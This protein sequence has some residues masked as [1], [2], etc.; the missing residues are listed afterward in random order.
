ME[1]HNLLVENIVNCMKNNTKL[2]INLPS[3]ESIEFDRAFQPEQLQIIDNALYPKYVV[4][5]FENYGLRLNFFETYSVWV[6]NDYD[7]YC[8]KIKNNFENKSVD[9]NKTL[10]EKIMKKIKSKIVKQTF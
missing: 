5:L 8:F 1:N 2:L 4:E 6:R 10:V 3:A 9:I 7:F